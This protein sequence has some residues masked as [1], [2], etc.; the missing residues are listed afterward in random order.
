MRSTVV[1][2]LDPD[3]R[4]QRLASFFAEAEE[5]LERHSRETTRILFSNQGRDG[6]ADWQGLPSSGISQI[7]SD[8]V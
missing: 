4:A 2:A 7:S 3:D 5:E 6:L 8:S 1:E